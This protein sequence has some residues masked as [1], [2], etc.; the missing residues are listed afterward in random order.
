MSRDRYLSTSDLAR[1]AGCSYRMADYWARTG[2]LRASQAAR[3]SG[4]KRGWTVDE[5]A[6]AR[7]FTVLSGLGATGAVLAAV[8]VALDRD[9]WLWEGSVVVSRDGRVRPVEAANV[10]GWVVDL[11]ACRAAVLDALGVGLVSA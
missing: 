11:F 1:L 8:S 2:V 4:S 7:A 9:P 6:L 10:D 5:V 3:G